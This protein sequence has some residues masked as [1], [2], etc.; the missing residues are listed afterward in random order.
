MGQ[1]SRLQITAAEQATKGIRRA[2]RLK[3][4]TSMDCCLESVL[5][6]VNEH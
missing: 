3:F 4:Q 2:P 5:T 6:Y 1:K